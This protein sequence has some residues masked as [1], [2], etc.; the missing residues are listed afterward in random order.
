MA[1]TT[2]Q[3]LVALPP[4]AST[5]GTGG[6]IPDMAL[7][8]AAI[9]LLPI[10]AAMLTVEHGSFTLWAVNRPFRLAGLGTSAEQSPL[11]ALLGARIAAFIEGDTLREEFAWQLGDAVD[12]RYY[13]VT[14]ARLMVNSEGRC[15]VTL[16]DQTAERRTEH[17]LRR[18]LMTDSLTGL[19]NRAGFS[20]SLEA[21]LAKADERARFA[22]LV[23]DLD[24]FSR[25][26][27]CL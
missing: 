26:H 6:R 2:H 22:M 9:D 14:L 11:L 5:V 27:A 17:N 20:E 8:A 24:R 16:L 7:A 1:P 19:A 4:I 13:R 15:L 21:L 3:A 25:V 23:I 10:P 18:E 12:C